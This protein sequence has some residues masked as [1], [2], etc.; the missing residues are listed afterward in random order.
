MPRVLR[1]ST[2]EQRKKSELKSSRSVKHLIKNSGNNRREF[3]PNQ[4]LKDKRRKLSEIILEEEKLFRE[5]LQRLYHLFDTVA[6]LE[7]SSETQDPILLDQLSPAS[8]CL[9]TTP[10]ALSKLRSESVSVNRAEFE[11]L[12][13]NSGP[14]ITL[15]AVCRS[16]TREP[17]K[18]D[19]P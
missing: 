14:C 6:D 2:I 18:L 8:L 19:K 5:E 11:V 1:K 4:M 3:L 12:E 16:S 13:G 7:P 10:P 15:G 9:D 17:L